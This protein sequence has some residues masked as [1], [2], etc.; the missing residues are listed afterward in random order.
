MKFTRTPLEGAWILDLEPHNDGRGFFARTFCANEFV[1]RGLEPTVAQ[2]NISYNHRRGT[3]RGMHYQLEPAAEAKLVRCT[4]GVVYDAIVDLRP[5]SPTHLQTFGI[6]LSADNRRA[7]YVPP[8][9]GHGYVTMA[10][11]A[12]V[13]YLVSEFYTPGME[14][15][16][17]WNDPGLGIDWPVAVEVISDKDASWPDLV[18]APTGA[19]ERAS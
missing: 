3:L 16:L 10:D 19:R 4:R 6:E 12:E 13:E 18:V 15:G 17:R 5:E 1:A 2:G 9:F 14:R 7:L 8:L 11:G